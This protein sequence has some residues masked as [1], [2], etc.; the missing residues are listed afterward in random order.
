MGVMSDDPKTPK[1]KAWRKRSPKQVAF[2][3]GKAE[4]D[5]AKAERDR[6]ERADAWWLNAFHPELAKAKRLKGVENN[7]TAS[8]WR[9]KMFVESFADWPSV[10]PAGEMGERIRAWLHDP[11]R[12]VLN[13]KNQRRKWKWRGCE[14][15]FVKTE[16]SVRKKLTELGVFR[17]NFRLGV[18][19]KCGSVEEA[20]QEAKAREE[21]EKLVKAERQARGVVEQ[22]EE[23]RRRLEWFAQR[24]RER[25]AKQEADRAKQE[26][27]QA[28]RVKRSKPFGA[29][30][31]EAIPDELRPTVLFLWRVQSLD[32]VPTWRVEGYKTNP[33]G[34]HKE[35]QAS[36]DKQAKA[37]EG[38]FASGKD[39]EQR[40]KAY[41]E[42]ISGVA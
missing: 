17:F 40:A 22:A 20:V 29:G 11:S 12:S 28:E 16:V 32:E 4:R 5:K 25:L 19:F 13:F 31:Y 27:E 41:C 2:L 3:E 6:S 42:A 37:V 35:W 14:K 39:A 23:E 18:W 36:R 21:A 15:N 34:W 24:D 9:R 38:W 26:A 7:K 33:E 8:A 10:L 30:W 1:R